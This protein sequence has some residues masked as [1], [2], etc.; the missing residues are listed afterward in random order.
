MSRTEATNLPD[1]GEIELVGRRRES[2]LRCG[3]AT[4]YPPLDNET[5]PTTGDETRGRVASIV[6]MIGKTVRHRTID[7]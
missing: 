5:K 4:G 1:S 7:Y 3:A 2:A 6:S